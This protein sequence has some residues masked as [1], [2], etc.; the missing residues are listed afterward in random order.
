MRRTLTLPVTLLAAASRAVAAPLLVSPTPNDDGLGVGGY[1]W[2]TMTADLTAAAGGTPPTAADLS[3]APLT[4]YDG[5]WVDVRNPD[6]DPGDSADDALSPAEAS[7]L[8][9]YI[10]T[11]RRV[12][13][14]GSN[15]AYSTWNNSILSLVGGTDGG[16]LAAGT[17]SAVAVVPLTA[18]VPGL[19]ARAGDVAVGGTT[20]FS[21]R[22]A[23]VWGPARN[24]LVLLNTIAIGDD[25]VGKSGNAAFANN[26]ARW[27]AGTLADPAVLWAATAGGNWQDGSSW[28]AGA[29]PA[30][31]DDVVFSTG[32][33]DTARLAGPVTART[34]TVQSDRLTLDLATAT[35]GLTV[36]STLAVTAGA[37][38]ALTHSAGGGTA[39]VSAATATVNGT[40][41]V[42]SG[43]GLAVAGATTTAAG[44]NLAVLAGGSLTTASL[45]AAG[46][47]SVLGHLVLAAPSRLGVL[48]LASG[49]GQLDVTTAAVVVAGGD[50][51]TLTAA[52]AT[53][54]DGGRWD[55]PGLASSARRRRPRPPDGRR[56]DRQRHGR[57]H[58]ALHHLRRPADRRRR[59]AGPVHRLRR[60][61]PERRRQRRRLRPNRQRLRQS[62]DRLGQRRL[63]LR[64]RR[65]RVGLH[66]D[67][68]RLRPAGEGRRRGRGGRG[69]HRRAGTSGNGD[70]RRAGG[71]VA[72]VPA[73]SP[74][75]TRPATTPFE[76]RISTLIRVSGFEL[77]TRPV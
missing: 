77:R 68:Q 14:V 46:S 47:T 76:F 11:G 62:S 51:P 24:V 69:C 27:A 1:A 65:R 48:G 39:A 54:F 36:G 49:T 55:G 29:M 32:A 37:S 20:L 2:T 22:V 42:G 3:T 67:R 58:A 13:L 30:V 70:G 64:R 71:W 50:L 33:T 35:A 26:L 15:S 31:A 63:Q 61:R 7:A 75:V 34:L 23:T 60:R 52:A 56:R 38:L 44:S 18:G 9:A 10:A 40:L 21:Q 19:Y 45:S 12:V 41:V 16:G 59:R 53:G 57:R 28:L 66:A 6:P 73:A 74:T 5:L 4:A 25:D 17:Y 72:A 43:S 8:S